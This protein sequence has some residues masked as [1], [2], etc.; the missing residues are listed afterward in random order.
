MPTLI[1]PSLQV[2][3]ILRWQARCLPGREASEARFDQSST[4]VQRRVRCRRHI[5]LS[6]LCEEVKRK[7]ENPVIWHGLDGYS[8]ESGAKFAMLLRVRGQLQK[9]FSHGQP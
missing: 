7:T 1:G 2:A 9:S 4:A 5:K 6:E 8:R 3:Q